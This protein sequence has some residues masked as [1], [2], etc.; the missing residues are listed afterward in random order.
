MYKSTRTYSIIF[1]FFMV[2]SIFYQKNLLFFIY[3]FLYVFNLDRL[4]IKITK[5]Y[6]IFYAHNVLRTFAERP[7]TGWCGASSC[8]H[9]S[10]LKVRTRKPF[11]NRPYRTRRLKTRQWDVFERFV[12]SFHT[13]MYLTPFYNIL[14]LNRRPPSF[15]Y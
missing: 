3:L 4:L 1:T 13:D 9:R 6:H 10:T 11:H 14:I 8:V 7:R 12:F 15:E 5:I 2:K